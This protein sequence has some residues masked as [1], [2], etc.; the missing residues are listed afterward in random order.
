VH[1]IHSDL[2]IPLRASSS[3]PTAAGIRKSR[4]VRLTLG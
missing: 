4:S 2:P 1:A 3:L